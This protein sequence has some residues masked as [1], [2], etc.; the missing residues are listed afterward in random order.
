MRNTFLK[1]DDNKFYRA[2][3]VLEKCCSRDVLAETLKKG[4]LIFLKKEFI[5][6]K[7]KLI[8]AQNGVK[9]MYKSDWGKHL[10]ND[11]LSSSFG[12]NL[13]FD[14]IH[15]AK[16]QERDV[17]KAQVFGMDVLYP[18]PPSSAAVIVTAL[19][20]LESYDIDKDEALKPKN[21]HLIVSIKFSIK[22]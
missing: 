15:D 3:L 8:I 10:V 16:A 4:V 20:L 13:T 21:I 14:D 11:I 2:P 5:I 1:E 17:L 6:F 19:K 7:V 12:G 22:D 18:R 9:D